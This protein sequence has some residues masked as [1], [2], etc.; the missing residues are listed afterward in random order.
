MSCRSSEL[1]GYA[2]TARGRHAAGI[3]LMG[4]RSDRGSSF[5]RGSAEAPPAIRKALLCDSGNDYAERGQQLHVR[6]WHD[7][8]V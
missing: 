3:A 5:V 2:M 4:I 8:G 7:T 1:L 6:D